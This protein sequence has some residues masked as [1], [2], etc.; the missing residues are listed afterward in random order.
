MKINVIYARVSTEDKQDTQRQIEELKKRILINSENS[1]NRLEIIEEK[2]SGYKLQNGSKLESLVNRIEE[3]PHKYEMLYVWEI[4]RLGRNPLETRMRVEKLLESGVKI[5]V[6][7]LKT[8]LSN[9]YGGMSNAMTKMILLLLLEFSHIEAQTTK[10]RIKSGLLHSARSGKV[11]GSQNI[12]YGYK[13]GENKQLI[14]CEDERKII[15]RIYNLYKDGLG[16]R[17]ISTILNNEKVPTRY[18]KI[19]QEKYIKFKSGRILGKDIRWSDKQIHDIIKNT[20]YIGERK[21]KG[22]ILDCPAIIDKV[23]FNYCESLR[24]NKNT[25]GDTKHIF[26]LK[27]LLKC[28][29]GRNM[30]GVNKADEKIYKCSSRLRTNNS[31]GGKGI[32]IKL[33]ESTVFH[34]ILLSSQLISFL[35]GSKD[36]KKEILTEIEILKSEID[37]LKKKNKELANDQSKLL[38]DSIKNSFPE[39][40]VRNKSDFYNKEIRK[41]Q[42]KIEHAE[43][44]KIN[45]Q[46]ILDQKIDTNYELIQNSK[47]D[48]GVLKS[49]FSEVI[50]SLE[51]IEYDVNFLLVNLTLKVFDKNKIIFRLKLN[52]SNIRKK[53][54]TY[55]Y[56]VESA[57]IFVNRFGDVI[58][59]NFFREDYIDFKMINPRKLVPE[60]YS[61]PSSDQSVPISIDNVIVSEND[62]IYEYDIDENDVFVVLKHMFI[63]RF[64]IHFVYPLELKE[65]QLISI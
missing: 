20:L 10:L 24:L 17:R 57:R 11:G 56:T 52:L 5:Y 60:T 55:N 8:V 50:T 18:N 4:S 46:K 3:E 32:N 58:E 1:E 47:N 38:D 28:K 6:E 61:F 13:K 45:K 12:P 19:H 7:T 53:I 51:V 30:V 59:M 48:R 15:E 26:L 2:I 25:K 54:K 44:N 31:C 36:L 21:F 62:H 23:T 37:N 63:E 14:I 64:K 40:L 27:N 65:E 29:C 43:M 42:K 9:D 49:L 16:I 39:H 22:E 34:Q 35:R 41:N 33:I